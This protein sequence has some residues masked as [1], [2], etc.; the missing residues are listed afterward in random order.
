MSAPIL[1]FFFNLPAVQAEESNPGD[2]NA[3]R[4]EDDFSLHYPAGK[5]DE[6]IEYLKKKYV[7]DRTAVKTMGPE[8]TASFGDEDFTDTYYDTRRL[9]LL[10]RKTGLRH[11]LR[12]NLLDSEDKKS[13]R[14]LI[15]LKVSGGDKIADAGSDASRNELKFEV[16]RT[17]S[18]GK[19]AEDNHRLLGYLEADQRL[20][21][22]RR[23]K[24][25]V[26]TDAAD[27]R[28][29]LTIEQRRRRVYIERDGETF[30]SF[31]VDDVATKR[32]W[33]RVN[34]S[35]MEIELNELAFTNAGEPEREQM[36]KLR[37]SLITD[38]TARFS[39]LEVDSDTKYE[40]AYNLLAARIPWLSR[41]I[42]WN[43]I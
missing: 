40:K 19:K 41:L 34:F 8:F 25:L 33:A 21:L 24:D 26:Q 38:L 22:A 6:I 5:S 28:P 17:P 39:Y 11:R 10:K 27:T 2:T 29:I 37:E 42:R 30:V 14:E 32:W 3:V 23:L 16:T 13:G 31:S 43:I 12:V 36:R 9:D 18:S 20:L 7:S 35:Q 15:Q 4:V 1:G